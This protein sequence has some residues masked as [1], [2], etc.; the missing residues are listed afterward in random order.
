MA[1]HGH[2]YV[3]PTGAHGQH[4]QPRG[5]GGMA[6]GAKQGLSGYAELFHVDLVGYA[7]ARR[8]EMDSVPG[9]GGLKVQVVVGVPKVGLQEVVV[10]VLGRKLHV[11]PVDSKAFECLHGY[12]PRGILKQG[13]VYLEGDFLSWNE[14]PLN[15]VVQQDLAGQVFRHVVLSLRLLFGAWTHVLYRGSNAQAFSPRWIIGAFC[16]KYPWRIH[17]PGRLPWP[18]SCLP[19]HNDRAADGSWPSDV[20]R[21]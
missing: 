17:H 13:L 9:T 6:V 21:S 4:G 12:G 2:G 8:A 11:D 3:Q 1:R 15:Q 18:S 5:A 14:F 7:V 20:P 16:I 10:H 19:G